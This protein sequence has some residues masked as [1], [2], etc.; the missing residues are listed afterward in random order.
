MN[1]LYDAY[2]ISEIY[3]D[4]YSLMGVMFPELRDSS[5]TQKPNLPEDFIGVVAAHDNSK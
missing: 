4:S 1:C 2:T 3:E 5:F